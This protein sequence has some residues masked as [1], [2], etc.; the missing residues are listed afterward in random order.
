MEISEAEKLAV[1]LGK[2]ITALLQVYESQTG[3]LVHSVPI[4]AATK[5]TPIQ[6]R[7]KVQ[8]P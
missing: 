8:L 4:V 1:Q 6:A 2:N 5:T 3:L 7:V